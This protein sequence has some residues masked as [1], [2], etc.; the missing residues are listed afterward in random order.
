MIRVLKKNPSG[1]FLYLFVK[2]P[3]LSLSL[4]L[5]SWGSGW[6][7]KERDGSTFGQPHFRIP[8]MRREGWTVEYEEVGDG[9]AYYWF[10]MRRQSTS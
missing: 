5:Y 1:T 10:W 7:D 3:F 2:T 8:L 9:F 4:S 6:A